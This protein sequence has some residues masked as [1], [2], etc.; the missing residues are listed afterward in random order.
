MLSRATYQ[1][2]LGSLS[3]YNAVDGFAWFLDG[4]GIT[5][6]DLWA[7][8]PLLSEWFKKNTK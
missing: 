2:G 6:P 8:D 3:N 5:F 1:L 4:L 7:S